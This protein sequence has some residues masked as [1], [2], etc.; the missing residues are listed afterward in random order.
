MF[1]EAIGLPE[2]AAT[3]SLDR[4]LTATAEPLADVGVL[5]IPYTENELRHW[6]REL[7]YRRRQL[8]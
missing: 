1:A 8:A 4:L 7:D 2:R 3:R 6:Q 5:K